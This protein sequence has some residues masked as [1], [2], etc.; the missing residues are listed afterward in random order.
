MMLWQLIFHCII[1]DG[2]VWNIFICNTVIIWAHTAAHHCPAKWPLITHFICH[3]WFSWPVIG[4]VIFNTNIY[5]IFWSKILKEKEKMYCLIVFWVFCVVSDPF[6]SIH[7]FLLEATN[8]QNT[9]SVSISVYY[10]VYSFNL[11]VGKYSVSLQLA[12]QEASNSI[13]CHVDYTQK[14]LAI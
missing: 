1:I 12:R 4:I 7:P 11:A 6:W 2:V 14:L 8:H 5:T 9:D 10:L 3:L 13:L